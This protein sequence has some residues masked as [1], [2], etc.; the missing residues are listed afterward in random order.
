ME[1]AM[2]DVDTSL[3]RTFVVLAE[4]RSFS[5]TGGLIGRSQSAV[6]GQIRKLEQVLGRVLLARNTRN[7]ALTPDGER[8]LGHARQMIASADAMLARFAVD[9]VKGTVRFGSPEDFAT[10]YLPETLGLFAKAHPAVELRVTC[11][12]TLPL[13]AAFEVGALDLIV[14]KQDPARRYDGAKPLWRESLVWVGAQDAEA[15]FEVLSQRPAALPLVA[16]PA[17]CVYRGRAAEAL[18]SAR[19]AWAG[20]FTSPSFAGCAAAV[21]AGFG[22]AVMPRGMVPASLRVLD[23]GWPPLAEAEIALLGAA[24]LS[25]AAEALATFIMQRVKR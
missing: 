18:D 6:S 9:E 11:Q 8:L 3:L 25:A 23:D 20:V 19:V 13:V 7:V 21:A 5:R 15:D 14:V 12:L 22:Y 16:S 24:R 10:T 2:H 4:T 1:A 17:P